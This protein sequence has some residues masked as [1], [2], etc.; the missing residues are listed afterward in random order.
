M[1][2]GVCLRFLVQL[3]PQVFCVLPAWFG[4]N[5][6]LLCCGGKKL[7]TEACRVIS[8]LMPPP[9]NNRWRKRGIHCPTL[10]VP[11]LV[12]R[13]DLF[14]PW[15]GNRGLLVDAGTG[16]YEGSSHV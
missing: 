7:G 12:Y 2:F 14:I 3:F 9:R 15:G 16:I 6:I 10:A 4:K 11:V 13:E 1:H 5:G 8:H